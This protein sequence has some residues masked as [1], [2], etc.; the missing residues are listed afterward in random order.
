M[1]SLQHL[2][3]GFLWTKLR[4]SHRSWKMRYNFFFSSFFSLGTMDNVIK[5]FLSVYIYFYFLS[6]F[7][8]TSWHC[9]SGRSLSSGTC[10]QIQTGPTSST[11]HR[12][13]GW[14]VVV[15]RYH[16]ASLDD[17]SAAVTV[18]VVSLGGAVG[19]WSDKRIWSEFYRPL[20]RGQNT[21][22][23]SV[24]NYYYLGLTKLCY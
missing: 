9:A 6:R 1:S 10:R 16:C 13:T 18:R 15:L 4:A 20:H 17:W 8:R 5:D 24:C 14:A 7:V 22:L 21:W 3:L 11:I 2:C 19:L 12:L 23:L